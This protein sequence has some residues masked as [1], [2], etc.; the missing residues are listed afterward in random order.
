[1]PHDYSDPL[2]NH[3]SQKSRSPNTESIISR[4]PGSNIYLKRTLKTQDLLQNI[5]NI[6]DLKLFGGMAEAY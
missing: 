3:L 5:F 2:R 1:M 4:V 6:D